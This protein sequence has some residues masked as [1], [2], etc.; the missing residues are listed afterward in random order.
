MFLLFSAVCLLAHPN[1]IDF[2]ANNIV[3]PLLPPSSQ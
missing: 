3:P 2:T 1:L